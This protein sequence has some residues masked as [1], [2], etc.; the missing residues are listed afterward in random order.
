MCSRFLSLLLAGAAA[1]SAAGTLRVCA[2]PNNLPF[3]NDRGEGFENRVAELIAR[4][5]N[6]KLE[7]VWWSPR[8]FYVRHTLNAGR[9]DLLMGYTAG[10]DRV[11][12]TQPYYT[13]TY[14]IVSRPDVKPPVKSLQDPRLSKLRIG[15]HIVN[16]DFA[17][18]AYSLARRGIRNIR[19]YSLYGA[20]G[21][22]NPP[23][24]LLDGLAKGEIDVALVWGP[25]AGYFAPKE[26]VALAVEPVQPPRDGPVPFTF[27]ISVALRKG[28]TAR[29][30]EIQ[31]VLSSKQK[32]IDSILRQYRVP[33]L[34]RAP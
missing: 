1:A 21:E 9:C 20:Y 19:G 24:R 4:E 23:A 32:E 14:V 34:R 29:L 18:P 28:D 11:L 2:D 15:A 33:Q 3:S 13:S 30:T 8:R 22:P 25:F 10:S 31:R 26:P 7:Y 6:S 16:E 17:P 5:T 12:T 27:G